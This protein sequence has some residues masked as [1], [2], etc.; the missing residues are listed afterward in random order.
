MNIHKLKI[1]LGKEGKKVGLNINEEKTKYMKV[2]RNHT[3]EPLQILRMGSYNFK[4]VKE[5][6]YLGVSI[7]DKNKIRGRNSE[8]NSE[9][10][11]CI[12]FPLTVI[13]IK[14]AAQK[15]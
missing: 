10:Q 2:T 6:T 7:T 8:K 4:S 1:E 14:P 11:S 9:W 3:K 13:Q 12:F 5:F 15:N